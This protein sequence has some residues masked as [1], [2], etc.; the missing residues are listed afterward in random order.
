MI[1]NYLEQ[2][3]LI[4]LG[5]VIWQFHYLFYN[6]PLSLLV[7]WVKMPMKEANEMTFC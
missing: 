7:K 1:N 2:L 4:L 3:L 5:L 6:E